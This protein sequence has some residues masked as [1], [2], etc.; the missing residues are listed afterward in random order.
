MTPPPELGEIAPQAGPAFSDQTSVTAADVTRAA[1]VAPL[2]V[3]TLQNQAGISAA[4]SRVRARMS[5]VAEQQAGYLPQ[6]SAGLVSDLSGNDSASPQLQLTGSQMVYDF[7]RTGRNV[8]R[9]VL[10]AQKAHLDFLETVDD[11]LA[12][13][14]L[15]VADYESQT[16]QLALGRDRLARMVTLRR[17]VQDRIREGAA[18][19]GSL[20]DA[21]RRVQ[22]AETLLL[23]TELALA[24]ARREISLETGMTVRD[25]GSGIALGRMDCGTTPLDPDRVVAVQG[26]H[27]DMALAD[28][29]LSN[30]ATERLPTV[31]LEAS[32]A[33]DLSDLSQGSDVNFGLRV[34]TR[35]F[36]GGA[37][38]SRTEAARNNATA[39]TANLTGARQRAQRSHAAALDAIASQ[40]V[41]TQ[42]IGAQID[43]LDR[44]RALYLRQFVELGT[45]SIDDVMTVEEEYHQTRLDLETSRVEVV[46]EQVNCLAAE[47]RLRHFLGI[48]D[49]TAFGLALRQ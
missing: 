25:G 26:A 9:Q 45:K 18:T 37:T 14:M 46:K 47:G 40:R 22:T 2:V 20:L 31:A 41:L 5:G 36:Q 35:L 39:V 10:L 8:S 38:Q 27:L 32:T 19:D 13:V 24:S 12:N 28:L 29:D 49:A 3:A 42:A 17:L 21:D 16:R 44:T 15:L 6:V 33:R 1:G 34:N 30:A 23:R 48:E 4:A 43:M 7:G 11:E